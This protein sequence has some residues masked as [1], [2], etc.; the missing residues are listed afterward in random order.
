MAATAVPSAS[1]TCS[2]PVWTEEPRGGHPAALRAWPQPLLLFPVCPLANEPL[3]GPHCCPMAILEAAALAHWPPP[4][5]RTL[6]LL[7]SNAAR[8]CPTLAS[9]G[10]ELSPG[11]AAVI[12]KADFIKFVTI[13]WFPCWE[14]RALARGSAGPRTA[15]LVSE[16]RP[17]PL[18]APEVVR[19]AVWPAEGSRGTDGRERAGLLILGEAGEAS[20]GRL[21]AWPTAV[22]YR[23]LGAQPRRHGQHW[24]GPTPSTLP[25]PPGCLQGQDWKGSCPI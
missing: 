18:Q 11:A 25:H 10:S 9:G 22:P 14:G 12:Y 19:Q 6:G 3:P 17:L 13:P 16:R 20:H 2:W 1:C 5:P 4:Q 23:V 8:L 24:A 15:C 7:S 21:W